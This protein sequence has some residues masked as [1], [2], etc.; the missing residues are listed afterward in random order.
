ICA[1]KEQYATSKHLTLIHR[2]QRP[3]RDGI[4]RVGGQL[5]VP[6]FQFVHAAP[7]H[8]SSPIEEQHIGQDVLN[9]I[10][11]V[12]RHKNGPATVE[13][14]VQKRIVKLLSVKNVEP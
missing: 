9:F 3:S 12:G 8:N 1:I 7:E 10:H 6:R 14:I 13:I 2:P 4:F 5:D 11:L